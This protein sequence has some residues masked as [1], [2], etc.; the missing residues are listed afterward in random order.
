MVSL[1]IA[2]AGATPAASAA[3]APR[4]IAALLPSIKKQH[5]RPASQFLFSFLLTHSRFTSVNL[6]TLAFSLYA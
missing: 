3:W 5:S 4:A 6:Q 1:L 2:V